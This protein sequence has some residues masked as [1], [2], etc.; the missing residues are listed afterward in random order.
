[1][2]S[3]KLR[4][5]LPGG[6]G[7]VGTLLARHFHEQGR[8]V[9]VLSRTPREAPWRVVPWNPAKPETSDS[10]SR[11]LEGSDVCINLA[12]RSVNCRYT[13]ANKK[14][15]YDSRI[16]TTRLLNRIISS[17]RNPPRLWLNMS[18]A[19]I[20]RHTMDRD[21]DEMTGELGG[22]EVGLPEL[23]R[24]PFQVGRDWEEAFFETH[25]SGIRKIAIR[26]AITL[27]P[28][29]SSIFAALLNLVRM[30]LGGTVGTG[31][32]YVS[33]IHAVDFLCA[34]DWLITHEEFSGVVNLASP[35]PIPN[36]EF[37]R[38]FRNVWGN[39]IGLPA[40]GFVLELGCFLMRTES[41]LVLKSRRVVPGR[42]LDS[43]FE[44]LFP[45]WGNAVQDLVAHW[46][47]ESEQ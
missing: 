1:M 6:S 33:W 21:M 34:V 47:K 9:T 14:E 20:Y 12:G 35:N 7:H 45:E 40:S 27:S 17:L 4:I 3:D 32:Q 43:G 30:G 26:S 5:V 15:I 16:G 28:D 41:E 42:L 24:F 29:R 8:H 37:M 46:K 44:F 25:I 23:W 18:T 11:E 31:Q 19:A 39:P 13:E 38:I 36:R 2:N 22:N 10:W